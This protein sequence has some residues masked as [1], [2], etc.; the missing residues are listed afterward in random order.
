MSGCQP[1]IGAAPVPSVRPVMR[2]KELGADHKA[3]S[4]GLPSPGGVRAASAARGY[5]PLPTLTPTPRTALSELPLFER[6]CDDQRVQNLPLDWNSRELPCFKRTF[7]EGLERAQE[8][9]VFLLR[10]L[11]RRTGLSAGRLPAPARSGPRAAG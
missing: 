11:R 3:A 6:T 8:G 7:D 5:P 4:E 10:G 2:K 1:T 9:G